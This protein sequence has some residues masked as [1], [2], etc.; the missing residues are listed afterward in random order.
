MD[1]TLNSIA[2][3]TADAGRGLPLVFLHGF[4]L[5]RGA[6]RKQVDAFRAS[7]RVIAPDLRGVGDS[8]TQ[9][10]FRQS[11][12]SNAFSTSATRAPRPA[13]PAAQCVKDELIAKLPGEPWKGVQEP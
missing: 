7:Y 4:P 9:P 5:S 13:A 12:P 1:T 10:L 3:S 8:G 2:L 11:P 6:W